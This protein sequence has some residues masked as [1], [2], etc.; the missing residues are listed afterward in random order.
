MPETSG[1]GLVRGIIAAE[2]LQRRRQAVAELW[3]TSL[4]LLRHL[5]LAKAAIH[6]GHDKTPQ[7][8]KQGQPKRRRKNEP[9]TLILQA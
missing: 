6:R 3:E 8:P 7:T 2:K 9:H 5:E 4:D 1:F